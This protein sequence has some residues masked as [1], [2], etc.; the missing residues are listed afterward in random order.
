MGVNLNKKNKSEKG[1]DFK[2]RKAAL[3]RGKYRHASHT[4]ID[5]R[6]ATLKVPTQQKFEN[7]ETEQAGPTQQ[8][9]QDI[10]LLCH[11]ENEKKVQSGLSALF[12]VL[13]KSSDLFLENVSPILAATLHHLR[14]GDARVREIV[15]NIVS[16]IF[17][18]HALACVPFISV[19]VRHVGATVSSPA[20]TIRLQSAFILDKI[21]MLPNLQPLPALFEV[22]PTMIRG[23]NNASAFSL[24]AQAITRVLK[25]FV[26]KQGDGK[27]HDFRSFEFP[28]LFPEGSTTFSHRFQPQCLLGA[29]ETESIEELTKALE[30]AFPLIN[31]D[32]QGP[33]VADLCSLLMVLI[34]LQPSLDLSVFVQF[35]SERFP[36][37]EA[38]IQKNVAI[39]RFLVT[40]EKTHDA[41][42]EFLRTIDLTP[43]T[44]VLFA[45]LQKIDL[46]SVPSISECL[47]ELCD[48]QICDEAAPAV[49]DAFL[50]HI[51]T[52]EKVTKR[53]LRALI[54]F[55]KPADFQEKLLPVLTARLQSVAPAVAELFLRLVTSCAPLSRPFLRGFALFISSNEV[56]DTLKRSCID[57]VVITNT[58]T[59]ASCL[60]SFI[61]T[62]GTRC[63]D[64]RDYL[65]IQIT[66]LSRL[67]DSSSL[68]LF[69]RLDVE[70]W[71]IV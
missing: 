50:S 59:D 41:V 18:R 46:S 40:S 67:A 21:A 34:E 69:A 39:A 68:P 16:W 23:A 1:A 43:D 65:R 54:S 70:H 52:A 44:V 36:Y 61:M 11:S 45:S 47:Q 3:G 35:A 66:R 6:T 42:R 13:S 10:L 25:R 14:N 33:A 24:F 12:S 19:F 63:P 57:A 38:P 55:K 53:T 49:A 58:T 51:M 17:G 7:V 15:Q 48:A 32:S 56:S 8:Q 30:L 9:L 27:F 29:D 71:A 20:P 28:S 2:R 5:L 64:L 22:F 4:K 37:E 60:L 62:I 31:G 26:H